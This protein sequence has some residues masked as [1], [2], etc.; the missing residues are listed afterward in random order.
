MTEVDIEARTRD[1]LR[2]RA[3]R[4]V[5]VAGLR[6]GALARARIIR[7]RRVVGGAGAGLAVLVVATAGVLAFPRSSD[8]DAGEVTGPMP[9]AQP[10]VVTPTASRT[11]EPAAEVSEPFEADSGDS[12][13]PAGVPSGAISGT[14]TWSSDPTT[15]SLEG[16]LEDRSAPDDPEVGVCEEDGMHTMAEY[17][18]FSGDREVD[19]AAQPAAD[20]DSAAAVPVEIIDWASGGPTIDRVVIR[21]CRWLPGTGEQFCGEAQEYT[22]P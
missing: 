11:P 19:T 1:S 10:P 9:G 3:D 12:C 8:G 13:E 14:L 7:R 21:I 18:A 17:T 6:A 22:R 4:T 2:A 15:F 5:P 16:T 20:G